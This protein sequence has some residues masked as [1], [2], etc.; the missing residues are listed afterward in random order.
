M[1]PKHCNRGMVFSTPC[2][3]SASWRMKPPLLSQLLQACGI[4][5]HSIAGTN[6]AP[7]SWSSRVCPQVRPRDLICP[8]GFFSNLI[9]VMFADDTSLFLRG[10]PANLY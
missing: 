3:V 1:D 8:H 7:S 10:E 9:N 2:L 4:D 6:L 5:V